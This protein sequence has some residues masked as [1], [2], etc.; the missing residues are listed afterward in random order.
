MW[1]SASSMPGLEAMRSQIGVERVSSSSVS[2]SFSF[3]FLFFFFCL[4]SDCLL[5]ASQSSEST[6]GA[7]KKEPIATKCR[8]CPKGLLLV[9]LSAGLEA[10]SG[11]GTSF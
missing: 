2:F 1:S 10:N 11:A 3:S 5:P 4:L 6:F 8:L 9:L 7:C